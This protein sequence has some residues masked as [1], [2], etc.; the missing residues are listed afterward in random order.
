SVFGWLTGDAKKVPIVMDGDAP[1]G[2]LNERALM[3]R[4]IDGKAKL[5]SYTLATRALSSTATLDEAAARMREFRA[6]RLPVAGKRGKDAGGEKFHYLNDA[7]GGF[8]DEAPVTPPRQPRSTRCSRRSKSRA[9]R[10][11]S[12][13]T[14]AACSASSRPRR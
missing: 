10:S 11:C 6:A 8:M 1:F 13:R 14:A 3:S 4:R 2:I 5:E 9:T 7:V 12:A